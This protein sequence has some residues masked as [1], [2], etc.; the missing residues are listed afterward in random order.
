METEVSKGMETGIVAETVY[1]RQ[2]KANDSVDSVGV[3]LILVLPWPVAQINPVLAE[4]QL[5]L[6]PALLK[7]YR[8]WM[9]QERE[10]GEGETLTLK[11]PFLREANQTSDSANSLSPSL[12]L[13]YLLLC[14]PL[15]IF[16]ALSLCLTPSQ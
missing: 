16:L 15:P 11:S 5:G 6:I 1:I 13:P 8:I 14:L 10:S 4:L 9:E 7:S 12:P 2:R 3:W